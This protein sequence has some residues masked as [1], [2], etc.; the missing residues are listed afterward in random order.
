MP[1]SM[2]SRSDRLRANTLI[3]DGRHLLW[4]TYDVHRDLSVV[5]DSTEVATGGIY[6]FLS[7]ALRVHNRYG[8]RTVVAWEGQSRGDPSMRNFRFDLYPAYKGHDQPPDDERLDLIREM[9]E[10][11]W[12]LQGLLSA[13]GVSQFLGKRCEGDDVVGRLAKEA[14]DNGDTVVIYSGDSDLRQLVSDRVY[15][16]APDIGKGRARDTV[17]DVDA[18]IAKHETT[19][20]LIPAVKALAGG[21][22]NLPG[23]V[24]VGKKRATM[25]VNH[26]GSL[27]GVLR[28]ALAGDEGWPLPVRLRNAVAMAAADVITY[29]KVSKIR[30]DVEMEELLAVRSQVRLLDYLRLYRFSTLAMPAELAGLLSLGG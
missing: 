14:S 11:E 18:V 20:A 16:A 21:K 26:Y 27:N 10:Q 23:V 22:D 4:R 3:L 6:G 9:A 8:G 29:Y 7:V 28:A 25:L 19:P 17:Y 2:E 15:V 1:P 13:C 24:G 5:I 12:R 30:T